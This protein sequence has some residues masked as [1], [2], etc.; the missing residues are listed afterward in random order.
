M[1]RRQSRREDIYRDG[2]ERTRESIKFMMTS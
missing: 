1:E 2:R